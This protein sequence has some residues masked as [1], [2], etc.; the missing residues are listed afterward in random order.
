M[1]DFGAEC[2]LVPF[3]LSDVAHDQ[4][5]KVS[6][7]TAAGE[8]V[9]PYTSLKVVHLT[10]FQ[11]LQGTKDQMVG[12]H[13]RMNR[14]C[15]ITLVQWRREAALLEL[16]TTGRS[17]RLQ[18]PSQLGRSYEEGACESKDGIR[19]QHGEHSLS[20]YILIRKYH[21]ASIPSPVARAPSVVSK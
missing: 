10:G 18:Y 13:D 2:H 3:G 6:Q 16:R 17:M 5:D 8:F 7:A 15:G 1:D 11:A 20:G 14:V 21:I 19:L 9:V 12:R 4:A